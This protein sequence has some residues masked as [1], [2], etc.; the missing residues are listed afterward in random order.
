MSRRVGPGSAAGLL[1]P[2]PRSP[3][4]ASGLPCA[5]ASPPSSLGR[6]RMYGIELTIIIFCT[7]CCALVS[8]SPSISASALL[9]FWRVV[10][11]R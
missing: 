3:S 10:M 9:I 1:P 6:R 7:F 2:D 8:A 11:V 4:P 5:D